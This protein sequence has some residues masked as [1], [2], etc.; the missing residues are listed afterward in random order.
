[1]K[2]DMQKKI[3][4]FQMLEANMKSLQEKAEMLTARIEEI[5]GT[6][7]A[8]DELKSAKPSKALIS[9]GSGNFVSGR[10]EDTEE[11]IIGVG[12]GVAIKKKREEALANLD[13]SL[14]ETEKAL[15][16]I[17]NQSMVIAMQMQKI[18]EEVEKSQK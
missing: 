18:Q 2:D 17:K 16:E 14:K 1:M 15:E 7:L 11:V 9:I 4:Q 5:E 8:M 13:E 12:G 6:K 10:I 3:I